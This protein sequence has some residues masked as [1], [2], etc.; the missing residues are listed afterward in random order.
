MLYIL[1][2][3]DSRYVLSNVNNFLLDPFHTYKTNRALCC[4]PTVF[5]PEGRVGKGETLVSVQAEGGWSLRVKLE[6]VLVSCRH[7]DHSH[8][9]GGWPQT[10]ETCSLGA[11]GARSPQV[12]P[13][14]MWS[15][16]QQGR[17]L[18][19]LGKTPSW[20][21]PALVAAGVLDVWL[22]HSSLCL[23][24]HIAASSSMYGISPSLTHEDICG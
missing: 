16:F 2:A 8:K 1:Y 9:L 24:G 14:G 11:L 23:C 4:S 5:L 18:D 13:P 10:P 7:S 19:A 22:H 17:P 3:N 15:R 6:P 20:P 21:L 12:A